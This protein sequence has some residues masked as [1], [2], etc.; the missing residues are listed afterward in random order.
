M[1]LHGESV[2]FKSKC[3]EHDED[4]KEYDLYDEVIGKISILDT[5][6]FPS[7]ETKRIYVCQNECDGTTDSGLEYFGYNYSWVVNLDQDGN[8]TSDTRY[9]KKVVEEET[10]CRPC[11]DV[12]N[13]F[14]FEEDIIDDDIM[15]DDW[16]CEEDLKH[17]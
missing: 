6:F 17:I 4:G 7:R 15:P 3:I 16:V 13:F 14:I 1:F 9:I 8:I 2:L 11:K 10:V 5:D 12:N